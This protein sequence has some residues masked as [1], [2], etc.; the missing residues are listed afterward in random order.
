[1]GTRMLTVAFKE[2]PWLTILQLDNIPLFR[3]EISFDRASLKVVVNR[4]QS[5]TSHMSS[6]PGSLSPELSF[7]LEIDI[8]SPRSNGRL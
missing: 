5:S 2:R 1:M 6:K 4:L 3:Y 8:L 7:G